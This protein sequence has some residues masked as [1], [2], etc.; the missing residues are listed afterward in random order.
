VSIVGVLS[1]RSRWLCSLHSHQPPPHPRQY[2]LAIYTQR[3]P[4]TTTNTLTSIHFPGS[5]DM[6]RPGHDGPGYSGPTGPASHSYAGRQGS[7]GRGTERRSCRGPPSLRVAP[8]PCCLARGRLRRT[9]PKSNSRGN[10]SRA[11]HT[12]TKKKRYAFIIKKSISS[13]ALRHVNL[14]WHGESQSPSETRA[15]GKGTSTFEPAEARKGGEGSPAT[16]N[17]GHHLPLGTHCN[18][19]VQL[20]GGKWPVDRS[21]RDRDR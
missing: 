12:H 5:D 20:R 4:T 6:P 3:P 2:E 7:R 19:I 10:C 17:T 1:D 16:G 21:E 13:R 11:S 18:L 8:C 14:I 15:T 9:W